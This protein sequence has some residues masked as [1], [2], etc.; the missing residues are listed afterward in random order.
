MSF[1]FLANLVSYMVLQS[2]SFRLPYRE[3]AAALLEWLVRSLV[4]S[5]FQPPGLE[6]TALPCRCGQHGSRRNRRLTATALCRLRV[7][8]N[9]YSSYTSLWLLMW[10]PSGPAQQQSTCQ[11]VLFE[12]SRCFSADL[13]DFFAH[14]CEGC[15]SSAES[16]T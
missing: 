8:Q 6:E 12:A 7:E 5:L 16:A 14:S 13:R 15:C 2:S 11:K 3:L 9:S 10:N 1:L 4:H